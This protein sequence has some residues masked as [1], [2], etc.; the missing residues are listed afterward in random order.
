M[1]KAF[2]LKAFICYWNK[3]IR[4][5]ASRIIVRMLTNISLAISPACGGI[6]HF[7]TKMNN[8]IVMKLLKILN[9]RLKLEVKKIN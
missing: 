3:L 4:E 5:I 1:K 9:I 8:K 6:N 7:R 2:V